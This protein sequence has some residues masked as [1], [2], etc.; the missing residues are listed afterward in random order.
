MHKRFEVVP[1]QTQNTHFK[2]YCYIIFNLITKTSILI[3]PAWEPDKINFEV[4]RKHSK[5]TNILLTHH[6][7]DH[8]DL[9][10]YYTNNTRINVYIS[11]P[12]VE[13][14]KF[15]CNNLKLFCF[16]QD[17]QDLQH[18]SSLVVCQTMKVIHVHILL[19]PQSCLSLPKKNEYLNRKNKLKPVR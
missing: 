19:T 2:N 10:D 3:D 6:H 1:V 17:L 4:Q 5:V 7:P 15:K 8:T 18:C 11:K 16:Q 9:I 13:Y 14:Y 12:E